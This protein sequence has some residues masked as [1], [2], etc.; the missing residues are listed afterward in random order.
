MGTNDNANA[1]SVSQI[2]AKDKVTLI[3]ANMLKRSR[4]CIL[5]TN[6]TIFISFAC[7]LS[8]YSNLNKTVTECGL[9]E[10][11]VCIPGGPLLSSGCGVLGVFAVIDG[12]KWLPRPNP[13]L[14]K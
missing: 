12:C 11:H 6:A 10:R 2:L 13:T 8:V 7:V 14:S 3:P 9:I 1:Y 4:H 5:K